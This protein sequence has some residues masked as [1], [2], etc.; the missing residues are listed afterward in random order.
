MVLTR[1]VTKR[2]PIVTASVD[3][4]SFWVGF[5]VDEP[6]EFLL[7]YPR[8]Q[9]PEDLV[10]T[11]HAKHMCRRRVYIGLLWLLLTVEWASEVF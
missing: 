9:H 4:W 3:F 11:T 8:W 6:E 1:I 10:E 2:G 7:Q 5:M